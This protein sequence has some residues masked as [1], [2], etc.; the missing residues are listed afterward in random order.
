MTEIWDLGD[1][2]ARIAQAAAAAPDAVADVEALG[3]TA[4]TV[5]GGWAD[6]A[7][8][9]RNWGAPPSTDAPH[10]LL[11]WLGRSADGADLVTVQ[12]GTVGVWLV[13]KR[14]LVD[15]TVVQTLR[16]PGLAAPPGTNPAATND[17][18]GAVLPG[19]REAVAWAAGDAITRVF[20]SAPR[21]G[22]HFVVVP[23]EATVGDTWAA[24]R[25]HVESLGLIS[26]PAL[27]DGPSFVAA[28]RRHLAVV[29]AA[30]NLMQSRFVAGVFV[31]VVMLG[32]VGT[33]VETLGVPSPAADRPAA[34]AAM[35]ALPWLWMLQGVSGALVLS[36]PHW[37][38]V[39]AVVVAAMSSAAAGS[40]A[41]VPTWFASLV[42]LGC[43][44]LAL[45]LDLARIYT[46]NAAYPRW[47]LPA[48]RLPLV[49]ADALLAT[50]PQPPPD[51]SRPAPPLP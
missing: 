48:V 42:V 10:M 37:I 43:L 13:F 4:L 25:E 28:G 24:H 23:A 31:V 39:V 46:S 12:A 15:G 40:V 17:H 36:R 47:W 20:S 33:R 26:P 7:R 29:D 44:A 11:A 34:A 18:D 45:A 35:V 51:P 14:V 8:V 27:L 30:S 41:D 50:Y 22:V 6:P 16:R 38:W 21:A 9:A 49:P 5:S 32:V 2:P 19:W 1:D 3:F